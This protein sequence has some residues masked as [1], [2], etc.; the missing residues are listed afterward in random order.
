MSKNKNNLYVS[1]GK[2]GDSMRIPGVL[3]FTG[4]KYPFKKK[5]K[6]IKNYQVGGELIRKTYNN[7]LIKLINMLTDSFENDK[8]NIL[9]NKNGN[10]I[11]IKKKNRG[12]FTDYCGGNVTQNCINRAKKSGNKTLIKR[13]VF[14][15][16]AR[17]WKH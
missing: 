14:A 11:H 17:K 5:K 13:A 1:K 2:N 10:K 8:D 3:D 6:I 9:Y 16:N 7:T 12:K 4:A 15:E